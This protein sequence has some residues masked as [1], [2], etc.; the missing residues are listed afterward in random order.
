M[1]DISLLAVEEPCPP[2]PPPPPSPEPPPLP[3]A[4]PPAAAER[5][6]AIWQRSYL[7]RDFK[8]ALSMS[9]I[10][11]CSVRSERASKSTLISLQSSAAPMLEPPSS[12]AEERPAANRAASRTKT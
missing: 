9:L 11:S 3:A 7:L 6:C 10:L 12:C 2:A 5:S 8:S 1:P 4:P